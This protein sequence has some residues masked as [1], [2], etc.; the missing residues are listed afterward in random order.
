MMS[1]SGYYTE[2]TADRVAA[3]LQRQMALR[4]NTISVCEWSTH[5]GHC[6]R[7]AVQPL[8]AFF[9]FRHSNWGRVT[10]S[11]MNFVSRRGQADSLR[12]VRYRNNQ[13]W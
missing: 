6:A 2:S 4:K 13:K 5:S 8:S 9:F 11:R 7:S 12:R 10:V 1:S 3:A